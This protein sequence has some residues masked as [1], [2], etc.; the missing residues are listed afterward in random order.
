ML[1]ACW[2]NN[3]KFEALQL[4]HPTTSGIWPRDADANQSF[5]TLQPCL[6]TKSAW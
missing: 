6:A 4:V 3:D 5:L 2:Y 1:S